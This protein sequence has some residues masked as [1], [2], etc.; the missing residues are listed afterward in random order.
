[1]RTNWGDLAQADAATAAVVTVR[2]SS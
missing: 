1:L 2:G